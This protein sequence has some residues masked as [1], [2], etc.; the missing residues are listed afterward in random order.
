MILNVK[1]SNISTKQIRMESNE[2]DLH[3]K[4]H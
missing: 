3:Y 4:H 2:I 1:L